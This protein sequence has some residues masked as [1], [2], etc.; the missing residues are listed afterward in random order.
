MVKQINDIIAD[1][2][3]I[4][5]VDLMRADAGTR[6]KVIKMLIGLERDIKTQMHVSDF[7]SPKA[8]IF[9]KQRL[10][11]LMKQVSETSSTA[12]R[13]IKEL[14]SNELVDLA[15]M[16]SNWSANLVSGVVKAD[17]GGTALPMKHLRNIANNELI[18]GARPFDWWTDQPKQLSKAFNREMQMGMLEGETIA[19]MTQRVKN[20]VIPARKRHAETL[21]RTSFQAVAQKTRYDTFK[22]MDDVLKGF[23]WLSTLDTRISAQCIARS[24]KRYTLDL[25]PIGHSVP[26]LGGPPIHFNCR[27][28]LV[29]ITKSWK[30]LGA[31]TKTKFDSS[32]AM[33]S[34]MG[35]YVPADLDYGGWLK[36]QSKAVQ[37]AALGKGKWKLWNDGAITS[38]SQLV[39]QTGR[40]L[41]LAALKD[42]IGPISEA[43]LI[44]NAIDKS[45]QIKTLESIGVM[46][47][48]AQIKQIVRDNVIQFEDLAKM[49]EAKGK[50]E[51]AAKFHKKAVNNAVKLKAAGGDTTKQIVDTLFAEKKSGI[52]S[53]D[54]FVEILEKAEEKGM[55]FFGI[56]QHHENINIGDSLG[57]SYDTLDDLAPKKLDGIST[58]GIDPDDFYYYDPDDDFNFAKE[59]EELKKNRYQDGPIVL[60]GGTD[61]EY[62]NDPGEVV[63]ENAEALWV[64]YM[65]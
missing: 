17:L 47:E 60:V 4:H 54:E 30:E 33:Q 43:Q 39:D 22:E 24:G 19:K 44:V 14:M 3:I 37:Q 65:K 41:T 40:P 58:M 15:K 29:P 46:Q 64:M 42:K 51:M 18:M 32:P 20:I 34:S 28:T 2:V 48:Q 26:A 57:V 62:G 12:Y 1:K 45:Q 27:S 50:T 10:A 35:G 55:R 52:P 38:L 25:K 31:K 23:T 5:N 21:V 59:I 61:Q 36:T 53:I 56:R 8:E 49:A 13:D 16:E 7:T 63:I 6:R 11:K 9:R